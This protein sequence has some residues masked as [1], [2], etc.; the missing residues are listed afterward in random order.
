MYAFSFVLQCSPSVTNVS[1]EVFIV[2]KG[3]QNIKLGLVQVQIFSESPV[4]KQI[5]TKLQK[6]REEIPR[7]LLT[8]KKLELEYNASHDKWFNR[9]LKYGSNDSLLDTLNKVSLEKYQEYINIHYP[10]LRYYRPDF[11]I[12]EL[13]KPIYTTKTNSDGKFQLNLNPGKYVLLALSSRMVGDKTEDYCWF[14]HIIVKQKQQN[15]IM[16]SND[17]LFENK[18]KENVIDFNEFV[19]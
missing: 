1:G 4:M 8:D 9:L 10:L 11:Y 7:L 6:V 13:P 12:S 15:N 17:N 3:G 5:N 16:L 19:N 2:T 18:S 14:I